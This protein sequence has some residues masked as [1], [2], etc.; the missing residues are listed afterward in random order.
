MAPCFRW[1]VT[2]GD[3]HRGHSRASGNPASQIAP[4]RRVGRDCHLS[5][6][7]TNT[8]VTKCAAINRV[9]WPKMHP[10]CKMDDNRGEVAP[11]SSGRHMLN[12]GFPGGH[13]LFLLLKLEARVRIELTHKGFADL[14]LTT[15]VPRPEG[16]DEWLVTSE[17]CSPICSGSS[18]RGGP[19]APRHVKFLERETGFE[20][21]TSTLARS[22]STTE[23][24]PLSGAATQSG[25]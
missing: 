19:L 6:R 21:A 8:R 13:L 25:F 7:L 18:H 24:F 10:F 5:M 1:G 3:R 2:R 20:P 15:W 9:F 11:T 16:L 17:T 23:L 4:K 12:P 14:S 22:H